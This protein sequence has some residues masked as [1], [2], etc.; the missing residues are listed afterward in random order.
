[1]HNQQNAPVLTPLMLG[2][3][4][5][6]IWQRWFQRLKTRDDEIRRKPY[7]TYTADQ[8]L[9]TWELGKSILFSI[10]SSNI[11]CTLPSV[12]LKDVWSWLTIV[13]IGTGELTILSADSD[14]VERNGSG[15]SCHDNKRIA[16]NVTL[17]LVTETQWAII[18]ATGIW[19]VLAY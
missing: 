15:I 17:Q 1:M 5:N 13:R 11:S 3:R 4:L 10:G 16:C 2:E 8:S 14:K 18:G 12:A 19:R 6:P 9:T 7:A